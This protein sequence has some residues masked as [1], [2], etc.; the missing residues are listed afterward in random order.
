MDDIRCPH[1]D[2]EIKGKQLLVLTFIA[3]IKNNS[4]LLDEPTLKPL[5]AKIRLL[6]QNRDDKY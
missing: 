2:R 3:K 6:I 5:F 4:W 1:C